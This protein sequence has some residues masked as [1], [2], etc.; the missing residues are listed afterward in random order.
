MRK[1]ATRMLGPERGQSLVEFAMV[2]P[3]LL[4]I[5]FG[6]VDFGRV[7]FSWVT[8]TNATREGARIGSLGS[9]AATVETRVRDTAD[10]LDQAQLSIAVMGAGGASGSSIV[11]ESDYDIDLITPLAGMINFISG[12]TFP[13]TI[14]VSSSADMRIE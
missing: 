8:V 10:T 9:D 1:L 4:V 5:M 7:F 14:T 3:L 12:G 11:V 6:I 13:E 2:L